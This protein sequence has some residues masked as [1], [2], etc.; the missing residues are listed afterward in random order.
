MAP[1][2]GVFD[3]CEILAQNWNSRRGAKAQRLGALRLSGLSEAGASCS[4][5]RLMPAAIEPSRGAKNTRCGTSPLAHARS[6]DEA[7]HPVRGG[8]RSQKLA[9]SAGA[10]QCT[11]AFCAVD[12]SHVT[13]YAIRVCAYLS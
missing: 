9:G 8:F 6:Y 11:G 7:D 13:P 10:A 5:I 4:S 2:G 12:G 1:P 3:I